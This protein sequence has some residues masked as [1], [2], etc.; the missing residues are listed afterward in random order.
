[1]KDKKRR[2]TFKEYWARQF[3]NPTGFG[4]KIATFLMNR[5]NIAMYKTVEKYAP[6]SGN[7]LDIGFGN[8]ALL[9]RL[10][11]KSDAAFDG[12]DISETSLALATKR[13]RKAIQNEKLAL[14]FGDVSRIQTNLQSF[15]FIYTVNTVYFWRDLPVALVEIKDKLKPDG[16]F[17]N[18]FYSK[19]WYAN[20]GGFVKHGF[21]LYDPEELQKEIQNSGMTCEI[22]TIKKDKSYAIRAVRTDHISK[23]NGRLE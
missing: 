21:T 16:V 12:I 5:M 10:I 7:I 18:V 9:R 3:G 2:L 11:K 8:G 23:K 17:L 1:M 14:F 20:K 19:K 4:G 22:I 13:N 6:K 15:D